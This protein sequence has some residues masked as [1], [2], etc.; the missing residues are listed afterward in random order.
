MTISSY[1]ADL[2]IIFK[3]FFLIPLKSRTQMRV[4][5]SL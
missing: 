1:Y 4:F 2:L 5:K 3:I